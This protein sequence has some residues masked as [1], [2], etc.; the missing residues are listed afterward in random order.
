MNTI[1]F[2]KSLS[3][4]GESSRIWA[5]FR[6]PR[7]RVSCRF[8]PLWRRTLWIRSLLGPRSLS[9]QTLWSMA[10][11]FRNTTFTHFIVTTTYLFTFTLFVYRKQGTS[12]TKRTII[13][14]SGQPSIR[15]LSGLSLLG[16]IS[17][18]TEWTESGLKMAF[19]TFPEGML[20]LLWKVSLRLAR[21]HHEFEKQESNLGS[22]VDST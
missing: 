12:G 7:W 15:A 21:K 2:S 16:L 17:R 3:L 8:L 9:R 5:I 1:V 11:T 19:P 6:C 18:K 14:V 4:V 10:K 13:K 20:V 22:V